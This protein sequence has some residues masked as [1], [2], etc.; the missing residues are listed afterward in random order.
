MHS[1]G[2]NISINPELQL[3]KVYLTY[4]SEYISDICETFALYNNIEKLCKFPQS[5]V[6]NISYIALE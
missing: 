6:A 5:Q 1:F 4:I 2:L 3:I